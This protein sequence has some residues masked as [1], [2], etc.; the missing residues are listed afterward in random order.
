MQLAQTVYYGREHEEEK[1]QQKRNRQKTEAPTTAVRSA[2]NSLRKNAQRDSGKRDELVITVERRGISSRIALRHLSHPW[3]HFRSAN[4]HT[5]G[6][7]A[8]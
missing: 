8:L 3:L 5:G 1:Q 7:N 6:E 4:D 2:L